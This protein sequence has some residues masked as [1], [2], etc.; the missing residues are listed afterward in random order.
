MNGDLTKTLHLHARKSTTIVDI[1]DDQTGIRVSLLHSS[2]L[3]CGNA[4]SRVLSV[5]TSWREI[6]RTAG[7]APAK[8]FLIHTQP[9]GAVGKPQFRSPVEANS[10][11]NRISMDVL[12]AASDIV[13]C[14]GGSCVVDGHT[15]VAVDVVVIPAR[16][17]CVYDTF[18][19]GPP[20]RYTHRT[21]PEPGCCSLRS[22]NFPQIS[23][24]H[25]R[26]SIPC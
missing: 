19:H 3:S 5:E 20:Y 14:S 9:C 15:I 12:E 25:T 11:T 26:P 18:A 22:H 4:T 10:S 21:F 6:D 8:T 24:M 7:G 17:T 13:Q 16:Y 1:L 2:A 23:K